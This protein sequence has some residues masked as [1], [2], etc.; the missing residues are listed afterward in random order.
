MGRLVAILVAA[1]VFALPALAG[2]EDE[3]TRIRVEV[4][5]LKGKPVE[6]ASVIV[7]FVQGRSIKKFGKLDKKSWELKTNQEGWVTLP[8]LPKGTVVVQV[9]AKNFQTYG[10][11]FDIQENEKTIEVQ[12][13]PPQAQYSAH[14]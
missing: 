3:L 11:T 9:I 13:K 14:Q 1:S 4:K 6:R 7:K 2:D 5:N 8:P 12:L 10:E